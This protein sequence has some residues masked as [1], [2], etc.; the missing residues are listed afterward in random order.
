[1]EKIK[2]LE[3]SQISN[4]NRTEEA[5]ISGMKNMTDMANMIY[6]SCC[7]GGVDPCGL[8]FDEKKEYNAT[9]NEE[10]HLMLP[11]EI[12][13]DLGI[14][15]G[16]SLRIV[17]NGNKL[18]I[19]PNIHSLSKLYIELTSRCN[20]ACLT[21]IRNTWNEPMGNMDIEVFDALIEQL[22]DFDNLKTVML[23]GFGEPTF[24]EDILYMIGR[25][26]SLGLNVEM[27]S[28]GTML[29]DA[30]LNGLIEKGLDTLWVSFDGTSA[31]NF[32]DIREGANFESLVQTLLRLNE[33]NIES[34][35]HRVKIGIAFVVMKRN[36]RELK[37]LSKLARRVGATKVSVSNVIP[38]SEDMTQ[39]MICNN[40]VN[41]IYLSLPTVSLPLMDKNDTTMETLSGLF[42]DNNNISIMHD[43]IS[44][45]TNSCRFIKERCSFIRWDG[46]VSPCMGLLH[47]YKTYFGEG[48]IERDV[49]HYPL[50]NIKEKSMKE[51]WDSQ[52]YHDF[53]EKVDL[54]DFSPCFH[55]GP[56]DLAEKNEEDCFG[57]TFPTCGG[58]LWAQG[59]IQ[60]P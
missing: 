46:V 1:M 59:V 8:N 9:V 11:P 52:E 33:L 43:K 31:E 10:K 41:D 14:T 23:G 60:C 39:Q 54:F 42:M 36:I 45:P 55:C 49:R 27:T 5:I 57:S 51:I 47:S 32:E 4:I 58:C 28:N 48:N 56:C 30:M 25:L 22:K 44:K 21:C 37:S 16:A 18:E 3:D 7:S 19:Y 40:A 15:S 29:D 20:L 35:N 2:S 17:N 38:Y 34:V 12:L 24:H 50:G 6:G 53:R 13:K 26:K